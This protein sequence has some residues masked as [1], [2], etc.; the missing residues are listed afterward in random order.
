MI[1][2]MLLTFAMMCLIWCI[3]YEVTDVIPTLLW[4]HYNAW[5]DDI[6]SMHQTL[7]NLIVLDN[8]E[9]LGRTYATVPEQLQPA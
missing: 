2:A 6:E 9:I 4:L 5:L 1:I 8:Q 7:D 3:A